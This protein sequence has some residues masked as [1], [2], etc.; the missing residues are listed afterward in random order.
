MNF[1]SLEKRC[2]WSW[3]YC[4]YSYMQIQRLSIEFDVHK[5]ELSSSELCVFRLKEHR[6]ATPNGQIMKPPND[7]FSFFWQVCVAI[8]ALVAGS[9]HSLLYSSRMRHF[10]ERENKQNQPMSHGRSN[11]HRLYRRKAKKK[12]K[13]ITKIVFRLRIDSMQILL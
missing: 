1:V 5:L 10:I 9:L 11:L 3:K 8:F 12:K 7:T 2:E 13:K 4:I 6:I